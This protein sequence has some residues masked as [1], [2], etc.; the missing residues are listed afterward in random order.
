MAM[1]EEM[2]QGQMEGEGAPAEQ[3]G[4]TDTAQV[5]NDVANGLA[6]V[7][8]AIMQSQV[9]DEVKGRMQAVLQEYVGILQELMGGAPA[10]QGGAEPME[11]VGQPMSP[12]GV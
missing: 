10:E 6:V 11:Q 5:M 9:P 12:A 4:A 2:A 1:Q 8:D 3:G 7:T